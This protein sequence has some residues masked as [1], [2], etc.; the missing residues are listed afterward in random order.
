M[1]KD[2][3]IDIC[4][5]KSLGASARQVRPCCS[6]KN[7]RYASPTDFLNPFLEVHAKR[8]RTSSGA[9]EVRPVTVFSLFPLLLLGSLLLFL[10]SLLW[11]TVCV[12]VVVVVG[13]RFLL[14]MLLL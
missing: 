13:Y 8:A 4:V 11:P 2:V 14:L 5:S 1:G 12:V 6:H 3:I 9:G 10:S 7:M